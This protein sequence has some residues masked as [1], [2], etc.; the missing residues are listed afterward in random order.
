[1][2]EM[3]VETKN[4]NKHIRHFMKGSS[5]ATDLVLKKFAFDL[6]ARIIKKMPVDLGRARAGWF[7]AMDK[8]G[9]GRAVAMRH[10]STERTDKVS[11]GRSEGRLTDHTGPMHMNKYIEIINGVSYIVFLEYGFSKQAAYGMVRVSMREIG[12]KKLPQDMAEKYRDEWKKF[13]L[14]PG[15]GAMRF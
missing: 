5:I 14:T 4:F 11:Q 8:L 6:V 1:M 7:V 13:Y 3:T 9:D 15:A 10:P 12:K 2:F